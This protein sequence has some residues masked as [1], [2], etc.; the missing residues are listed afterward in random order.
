[1][2]SPWPSAARHAPEGS[3][4]Q[5]T[6]FIVRLAGLPQSP[7]DG[8]PA[9]SQAAEGMALRTAVRAG[10]FEIRIC[11][12]RLVE[13]A[14]GPLYSDLAE[15]PIA[16]VAKANGPAFAAAL[17]HRAGAGQGLHAGGRGEAAAVIPE[18]G[19]ERRGEQIFRSG[20]GRED[21]SVRMP[22]Q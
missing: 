8:Q 7:G 17:G 21:C 22:R 12:W 6:A 1:V 3:L 10:I 13:G 18:L 19:Q 20:K 11:P 16:G 9:V 4:A 15:L 5:V 14:A 2:I